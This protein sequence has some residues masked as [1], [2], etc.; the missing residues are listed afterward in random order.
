MEDPHK[1]VQVSLKTKNGETVNNFSIVNIKAI[2][3][4]AHL[5]PVSARSWFVNNR[6][7]LKTFNE[8]NDE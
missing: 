8:I 5:V 4:M 7:D 3:G 6:I 1:L 2:M